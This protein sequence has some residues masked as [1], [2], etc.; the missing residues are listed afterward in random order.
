VPRVR[1]SLDYAI[2]L[3]PGAAV[4]ALG[5]QAGGFYPDSWGPVA[6]VLGVLLALRLTL[7]DRPLE[8][9]SAPLLAALSSFALLALWMLASAWWSHSPGRATMEYAR[10]LTY[11]LMLLLLGSTVWSRRRTTVALSGVLVG[12]SIVAGAG[13]LTRV[14]PELLTA[15]PAADPR[16]LSWPITYWNGMGLLAAVGMLLALHLAAWPGSSRVLRPLAAALLPPLVVTL[17]L[18]LSRGAILAGGLGLVL[19][20]VLGRPRA[21][22]CALLAAGAPTV[23]AVLAAYHA[24]SLLGFDPSLPGTVR[25]GRHVGEEVATAMVAA[26]VLR[27]LL[28]PIDGWLARL[29]PP[30][31]SLPVRI[32]L[33]AAGVAVLLAGAFATGAAAWAQTQGE[34]FLQGSAVR[35]DDV[36]TRLLTVDN[37]G[38]FAIWRVGL[39]AFERRPLAGSGAGTF[40]IDWDLDRPDTGQVLDAHSL[41]VETLGELGVVGLTLLTVALATILGGVAWRA[42]GPERPLYAA[43]LSVLAIWS[44]HAAL[45][46]DWELASVSIWVFGLAGVALAARPDAGPFA[47]SLGRLTRVLLA[48]GCL[49]L[50]LLPI[51]VSRSQAR[52]SE[53]ARAFVAGDCAR[54]TDA[55]LDSIDALSGRADPWELL[56]YCDIRAG[57]PALALRAANEAV[58]LDP[59]SWDRHY[60]LALAR[61]AAGL[62][63][64]PAAARSLELNPLDSFAQ[65]AVKAFSTGGPRTWARRAARLPVPVF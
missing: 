50:L 1:T 62:D 52:V 20:V 51:A 6:C 3:L 18:T 15:P 11:L 29:T 5:F 36:R 10:L 43:V 19:Y 26:A 61:A 41:Y 57:E 63:P 46:W 37:D 16:R 24:P 32:G 23:L 58:R 31:V 17:Y 34:T 40:E 28:L 33:G 14:A 8:G 53:A 56:T 47:R 54:T 27:T 55:S 12:I 48:L 4:A 30:R 2:A 13:L 42:R 35:G 39:D 25:D 59:N 7:A 60:A 21:L 65:Q 22:I 44:V 49:V 45:D 38:R 64:R 9:L